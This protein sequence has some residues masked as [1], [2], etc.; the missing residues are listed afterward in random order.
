MLYRPS[1]GKTARAVTAITAATGIFASASL[2]TAQSA[3]AD[4]ATNKFAAACASIKDPERHA[5]CMVGAIVKNTA[6]LK[7]DEKRL[8]KQEQV[9]DIGLQAE[10]ALKSC[11]LDLAAFKK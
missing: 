7:A 9:L 1:F 3:R 4:E 11:L 6:S 10:A 8:K 5:G 2:F